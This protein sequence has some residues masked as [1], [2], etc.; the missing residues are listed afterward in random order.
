MLRGARANIARPSK[1]LR[2]LLDLEI[3]PSGL[4]E[5]VERHCLLAEAYGR[6]QDFDSADAALADALSTARDLG[7]P[8]MLAAVGYR[9]VRRHLFAQDVSSARRM[10][11]LARSGRSRESRVYALVAEASILP[12]EERLVDQTPLLVELL[13]SLD[14]NETAFIDV[15]AWATHS[16]AVLTRDV[17]V[18]DAIAEVDRQLAGIVWPEDYAAD[19]FLTLMALGWA[20]AL[21]GDTFNAFRHLKRASDVADS[22]SWKVVAA[23]D[24]AY[25]A[26]CFDEHRWSRIELDEA[27]RL[28]D[29][30]EWDAT[31]GEERMGLLFLAQ[32]FSTLDG[33][34]ASMYLA[35]YRELGD[36][37]STLFNRY[38][39][40]RQAFAQYATGMVEIALGNRKQ[41]IGRTPPRV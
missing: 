31:R 5:Q 27:E 32:L 28:A 3:P 9:S 35:R 6:T 40:R 37:R 24:R 10:L 26:R 15:R 36:V 33:A 30:V 12:Y 34:K 1:S 4:R 13:R 11:E 8:D 25:L 18:P 21:Q 39:A 7:D 19:L 20:K 17:Y 14:P 29:E 41:G 23:C 2:L 22:N 38:D 16:L